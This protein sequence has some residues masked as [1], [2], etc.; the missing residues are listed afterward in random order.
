M[1]NSFVLYVDSVEVVLP[2]QQSRSTKPFFSF[3]CTFLVKEKYIC[4]CGCYALTTLHD[5]MVRYFL[6]KMD[7]N[8]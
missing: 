3:Y 1:V 4:S 2:W 6:S 7:K 5:K 8:K